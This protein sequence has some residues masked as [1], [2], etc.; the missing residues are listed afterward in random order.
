MS[1]GYDHPSVELSWVNSETMNSD[2]LTSR[3][4]NQV[5]PSDINVHQT[6]SSIA[7]LPPEPVA[8]LSM[9][10]EIAK[11]SHTFVDA[12][13]GT[14]VQGRSLTDI[15]S[16]GDRH[17][18]DGIRMQ[19]QENQTKQEPNYLPPILGSLDH[20]IQRL[21]FTAEEIGRYQPELTYYL[22][23]DAPEGWRE[24]RVRI[25][26]AK[27]ASI[28]FVVVLLDIHDPYSWKAPWKSRGIP[29]DVSRQ[30]GGP[31][32]NPG[33]NYSPHTPVAIMADQ[34]RQVYNEGVVG[35]RLP[36]TSSTQMTADVSP[37]DSSRVPSYSASPSHSQYSGP[38]PSY[39]IPRSELSPA[40][41][42]PAQPFYQL[43]PIRAQPEQGTP[44]GIQQWARDDR[45]GRVD[46][47]GL[48]DK[49]YSPG[50]PH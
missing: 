36:P 12:I 11:A 14:S 39:H 23:F 48:I 8:F 9:K 43:P 37:N 42:P 41:R 32:S 45:S 27:E 25:G 13:G 20:I 1:S 35:S 50:R 30:L 28:Y 21:G 33:S 31:S 10:L 49:P 18:I 38:S 4:S 19:L 24:Y 16:S 3:F 15:V 5:S 29:A 46:I 6:S 17:K 2:P 44:L 40:P 22:K 34:S 47:G 7:S 26:L